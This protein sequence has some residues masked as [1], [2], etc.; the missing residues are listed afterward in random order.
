MESNDICYL[1]GEKAVLQLSHI[2]P[3]FVVD[4]LKSTSGTGFM[5]RGNAPNLRVPDGLKR[6]L[7]CNEC[8]QRFNKWETP[9][10]EEIF[11]PLHQERA[12]KF[13]KYGPWLEKFAV[14]VSW[15]VL[16]LFKL[17]G[18]LSGFPPNL[19]PAVDKALKTWKEFLLG[20]R[21]HPGRFEHHMLLL[22][23]IQETTLLTG[24]PPNINRYLLRH[25]HTDVAYSETKAFVYIKLCRILLVGFIEMP[26]PN[27]WEGTK[28][29]VKTGTFQ[30]RDQTYII[31]DYLGDY[32]IESARKTHIVLQSISERQKKRIEEIYMLDLDRAAE[33]E[34]FRAMT[35]DVMM[36]G[37]AAFEQLESE[38]DKK[39]E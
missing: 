22:G 39:E 8:E 10:A 37:D 27:E 1:C 32:L 31:P 16:I 35:Y 25:I 7:L 5:R 33:S 4:W 2:I 21:P 28:L 38:N 23:P 11:V 12:N 18:Y 14:S 6:Y 30:S 17:D 36:F 24:L 9:F 20:E 26:N 34:S 13:I 19:V 15:R 29:R 3:S